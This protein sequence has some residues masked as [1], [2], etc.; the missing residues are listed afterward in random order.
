MKNV[1]GYKGKYQVTKDGRIWSNHRNRFLTVQMNYLGY[2]VISLVGLGK[3][4]R[5]QKTHCIHRLVAEA[6]LPKVKDKP[7]INHKD[8]N[9]TNNHVSNL[10]W[11]TQKENVHHAWKNNLAWVC[12]GDSH[13]NVK[14]TKKQVEEINNKIDYKYGTMSRLAKEYGVSVSLISLIGKGYRI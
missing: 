11:C 8:G 12:S 1:K 6:Y 4:K 7:Q 3:N 13:P 9:K 14:L 2:P 10:E 5:K